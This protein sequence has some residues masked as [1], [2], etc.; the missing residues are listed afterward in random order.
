[1]DD[2]KRELVQGWLVKAARDLSTA[3][4]LAIGPDPLLDTAIY[5]CQQAAEKAIKGFLA[6]NDQLP[7]KTHDIRLLATLAIPYEAR[8]SSWRDL[9]ARLTP[10]ATAFR[11]PG[12]ALEPGQS[13]FDQALRDAQDLCDFVLSLL[14]AEV[15]P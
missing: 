12:G 6:F 1:M 15:H 10:Y 3:R 14:P 11:Y 5:H 7:E 9:G 13:E 4:K 8:F 2:A